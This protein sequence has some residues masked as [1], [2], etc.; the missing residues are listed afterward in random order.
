MQVPAAPRVLSEPGL[1]SLRRR[2]DLRPPAR[3]DGLQ[4]THDNGSSRATT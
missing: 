4:P 2:L 1:A 3:G